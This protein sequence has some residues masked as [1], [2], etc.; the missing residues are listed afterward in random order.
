M[1][2]VARE[3][4]PMTRDGYERLRAELDELVTIRRPQV[5]DELRTAR[6][7]GAEASENSVM[8]AVLA[9]RAGI[10]RR[11]EE[12]E[13]ALAFARIA[14]P[15]PAGVAGIGRHVRIR[16]APADHVLGYVLVGAVEADAATGRISIESP[17]GEALM[18][19]RAGE[20]VEVQ[21]PGGLR[22]VEIVAVEDDEG[23]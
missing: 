16:V 4:E 15:P 17:I 22:T 3:P 18:G 8:A 12:L 5:A 7:E 2:I 11:I 13:A 20:T 21:T 1:S 19:R 9:D 14:E 10:E 6:E 23:D